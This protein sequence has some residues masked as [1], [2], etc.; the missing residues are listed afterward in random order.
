[1]TPELQAV[2]NIARRLTPDELPRLLGDLEMV[3][4]TVWLRLSSP[5][6]E[7]KSTAEL[8]DVDEAAK[9]LGMSASYLY[10]N[11][12]KFSFS[13]KL[14]HSLRFSAEGIASYIQ[15][16]GPRNVLTPRRRR[17]MIAPVVSKQE[18]ANENQERA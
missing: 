2:L 15:E 1:M 13:R 10:R 18:K 4:V 8:V 3:R 14:G 7:E 9:R 6:P 12:K 16:S 5:A 11:H 17:P